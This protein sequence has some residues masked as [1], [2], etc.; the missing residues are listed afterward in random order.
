MQISLLN[1]DIL[2]NFFS[3]QAFKFPSAFVLKPFQNSILFHFVMIPAGGVAVGLNPWL[4]PY[5]P[6]NITL[7]YLDLT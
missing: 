7:T 1:N 4:K 2:I 3:A 5:N 6:N